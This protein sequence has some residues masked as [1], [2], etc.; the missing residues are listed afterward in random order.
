MA[1]RLE[2]YAVLG[3]TRSAAVV[4]AD[5]SIDWLCVPR[6][7]SGACFAALL[8][9]P[10]NGR[11]LVA[12]A[13]EVKSTR[14]RYLDDTLV[15]ETEHETAEGVVAVTDFMPLR[16]VAPDIVRIV[17]GKRGRVPMRSELVIRFDYGSIVPWV[18]RTGDGIHAVAG[19]DTLWLH[20]PVPHH[21]E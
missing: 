10:D 1:L 7:D 4:G 8:G 9:T 16:G 6:F 21:G 20:T 15:L 14:R 18:H 17:E 12:P 19:P 5:G 13:G 3:N 11:W 2:E